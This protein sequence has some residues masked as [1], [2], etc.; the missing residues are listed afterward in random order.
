[1]RSASSLVGRRLGPPTVR[2]E[3]EAKTL[4]ATR[5]T[6]KVG[7]L[8]MSPNPRHLRKWLRQALKYRGAPF[9]GESSPSQLLE[10]YV[11]MGRMSRE[12][13]SV[14]RGIV[15]LVAWYSGKGELL[16][17]LFYVLYKQVQMRVSVC[18][19]VTTITRRS[20]HS[21]SATPEDLAKAFQPQNREISSLNSKVSTPKPG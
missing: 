11:F 6:Q 16:L 17:A 21:G 1:M 8:K 9:D 4:E 12:N 14:S 19:T 13:E 18:A 10:G 20:P 2:G 7:C 3:I 5:A 15:N